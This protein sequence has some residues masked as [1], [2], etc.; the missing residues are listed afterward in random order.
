MGHHAPN[1]PEPLPASDLCPAKSFF[2]SNAAASYV[3]GS[4]AELQTSSDP[5]GPGTAL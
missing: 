2:F 5:A 4:G 1:T 3:G